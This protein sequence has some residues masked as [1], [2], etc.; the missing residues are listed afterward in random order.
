MVNI[1]CRLLSNNYYSVLLNGHFVRFFHST[2]VK[3]GDPLSLALFILS[4]E[5]LIRD[6][7]QDFKGSTFIDYDMPKWSPELNHLA[8]VD[9]TI[10]FTS[11]YSI[12]KIM[13]VLKE[14]EL[15]SGQKIIMDKNFYYMHQSTL[16]SVVMQV[17]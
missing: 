2:R 3:K 14:Y 15:K 12:K 17:K 10:I 7:N 16:T 8:Y 1:I 9:D 6:F 5:V 11:L 13:H 4:A